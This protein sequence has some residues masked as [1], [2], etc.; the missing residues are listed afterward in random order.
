MLRVEA[1]L[2]ERAELRGGA[3]LANRRFEASKRGSQFHGQI[4]ELKIERKTARNRLQSTLDTIQQ[5]LMLDM[6][7]EANEMP[8]T[9]MFRARNE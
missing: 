3:H 4:Q 5:Y 8:I 1:P 9:T 2:G 7:Q 6:E